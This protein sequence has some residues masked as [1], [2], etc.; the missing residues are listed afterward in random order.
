MTGAEWAALAFLMFLAAAV[1]AIILAWWVRPYMIDLRHQRD[2]WM[3]E[4]MHYRELEAEGQVSDV[5]LIQP[6][7][8]DLDIFL[9]GTPTD[10]R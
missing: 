10:E 3:A 6:T 5:R 2:V 8:P 1:S 9:K 4:A 7:D